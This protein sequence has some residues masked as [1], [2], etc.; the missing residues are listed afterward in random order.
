LSKK[1]SSPLLASP[2]PASA[3]ADS[4]T[5]QTS[6][7][8]DA[9]RKQS[10][11]AHNFDRLFGAAATAG[12]RAGTGLMLID[13]DR[14]EAGVQPRRHFDAKGISELA[15]SIRERRAKGEG[16]EASGLLQPLLVA[17]IEGQDG[18]FRLVAGER[19]FRASGEAGLEE[20]PAIVV[21]LRPNELLATQLIE[22]LQRQ[23]LNALDEARGIQDLM[24][25]RQLSIRQV[26]ATL[27]KT[28][29][30][31][32]NRLDLLKMGD[33]VQAMV[34]SREDTLRTAARINAITD[35]TLRVVL[36][37]AVLD[38][39]IGEREVQKRIE[40]TSGQAAA[41]T[42][43]TTPDATGLSSREDSDE[44]SDDDE[45]HRSEAVS[46]EETGEE[47]GGM[48]AA[49]KALSSIVLMASHA[50]RLVR[51]ADLSAEDRVAVSQHI[52]II[53]RH[54]DRIR[55]KIA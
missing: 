40:A 35:A 41:S 32:T 24:R 42:D 47:S 54:L 19:R 46:A 53:Q 3:A 34:S 36:I 52:D 11:T 26:A 25:A 55:Q 29:G 6:P 8:P 9:A 44:R 27:G 18:R 45:Q 23:N 12:R 48:N 43:A 1:L 37:G 21:P 51:N 39:H 7:K 33:D 28:R 14:I 15:E 30:Y 2:V 4:N 20:V 17:P 38:D 31:I 10:G 50:A 5:A 22:N 13:R 49:A 16:V